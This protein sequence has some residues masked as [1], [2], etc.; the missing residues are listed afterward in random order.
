MSIAD[1]YYSDGEM[2]AREHV[3]NTEVRR[4]REARERPQLL[5][6]HFAHVPYEL[7]M[8]RTRYSRP[9]LLP[10][11]Q[12]QESFRAAR[13][14]GSEFT[15]DEWFNGPLDYILF[16]RS[17][18]VQEERD[19]QR[20]EEESRIGMG[21]SEQ[22]IISDRDY[23]F[24]EQ[25]ASALRTFRRGQEAEI[26]RQ[27]LDVTPRPMVL[28]NHD[29]STYNQSLS[30]IYR[31]NASIHRERQAEHR[32]A[33]ARN[34]PLPQVVPS[35]IQRV[36]RNPPM[37]QEAII[38]EQNRIRLEQEDAEYRAL[39]ETK[40]SPMEIDEE[41]QPQTIEKSQKK[42]TKSKIHLRRIKTKE[43]LTRKQKEKKRRTRDKYIKLSNKSRF[44]SRSRRLFI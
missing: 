18:D 38:A 3:I 24:H 21:D 19:E 35:Q 31:N 15:E 8:A 9:S 20:E 25:E 37:P 30:N 23:T 43:K 10:H 16:R 11:Y 29:R 7:R 1:P 28:D 39:L 22:N 4:A 42:K 13:S 27:V 26:R 2:A 34:L 41:Q 6:Q 32:L 5:P 36:V 40:N 14:S 33:Q 44:G 12:D 17:R